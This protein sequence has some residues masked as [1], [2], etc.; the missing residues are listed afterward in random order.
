MSS[1]GLDL[2]QTLF[3]AVEAQVQSK[4]CAEVESAAARA[5]AEQSLTKASVAAERCT[6]M[7]P[8][9]TLSDCLSFSA[10]QNAATKTSVH[11]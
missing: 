5:L 2:L 4:T 6:C 7:A 11:D 3:P 1:D 8:S 9:E 10:A